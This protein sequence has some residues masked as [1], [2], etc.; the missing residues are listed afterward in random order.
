MSEREQDNKIRTRSYSG[1][2]SCMGKTQLCMGNVY[3][4]V[5]TYTYGY[6]VH[7][8]SMVVVGRYYTKNM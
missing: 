7:K 8:I 5:L 2:S 3:V 1:T 6:F 4:W